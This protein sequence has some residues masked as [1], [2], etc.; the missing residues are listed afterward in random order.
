[1]RPSTL[2]LLL[3]PVASFALHTV[4]VY[5]GGDYGILGA[6]RLADSS[7]VVEDDQNA[8]QWSLDKGQ[9]WTNIPTPPSGNPI[10]VAGR[11]LIDVDSTRTWSRAQGWHAMGLPSSWHLDSSYGLEVLHDGTLAKRIDS[12]A[13]TVHF[14][15]PVD[16]RFDSLVDWMVVH[17][18]D[19][20]A[21]AEAYGNPALG[22]I[23]YLVSDSGYARG[24]SDGTHWSQV[25]FPQGRMPVNLSGDDWN[26]SDSILVGTGFDST[27][28]WTIQS[29][30]RGNTWTVD[31]VGDTPGAYILTQIDGIVLS[32]TAFEHTLWYGTSVDGPWTQGEMDMNFFVDGSE[33]YLYDDQSI[34]RLE[35]NDAV[36]KRAVAETIRIRRDAKGLYAE[37]P[38][39]MAGESW[40]VIGIDGRLRARGVTPSG[41]LALPSSSTPSWLRVGRTRVAL[42]RI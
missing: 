33:V 26:P 16:E 28:T 23:W 42:P 6:A 27:G 40:S 29:M 9:N 19:I 8:L 20:P 25:S 12:V 35:T 11:S 21:T 18:A 38:A 32:E 24:T 3:L 37:I 30:D 7:W 34:F 36:A 5:P 31:S 15:K 22:K 39:T 13:K 4:P 17:D 10:L 2:T 14:F 1:M 41:R